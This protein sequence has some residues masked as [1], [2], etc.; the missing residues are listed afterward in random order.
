MLLRIELD[1]H[2]AHPKLEISPLHEDSDVAC[3][4]V[5]MPA[6]VTELQSE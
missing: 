5:M 6:S 2:H 1:G 3:L 4:Q